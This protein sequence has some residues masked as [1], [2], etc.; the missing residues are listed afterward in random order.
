V[1]LLDE[2]SQSFSEASEPIATPYTL[3]NDNH[4]GVIRATRG[5]VSSM[6]PGYLPKDSIVI[7]ES[8]AHFTRPPDPEAA[9]IVQV[10][11]GQFAGKWVVV[12]CQPDNANFVITC[13]ASE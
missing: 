13:E 6:E 5:E 8:I 2:M 12:A 10:L 1:S 11:E 9:E 4:L 7:V 3:T